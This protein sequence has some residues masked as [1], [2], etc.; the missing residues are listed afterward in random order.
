MTARYGFQDPVALRQATA[1]SR[2]AATGFC[3]LSLLAAAAHGGDADLDAAGAFSLVLGC[4]SGSFAVALWGARRAVE[5]GVGF[6]T[7]RR[8][9]TMATL[10]AA[11]IAFGWSLVAL[12]SFMEALLASFE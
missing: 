4:L 9:A 12:M 8:R 7:G 2:D 11:G 1:L 6:A 5:G 10:I 3:L